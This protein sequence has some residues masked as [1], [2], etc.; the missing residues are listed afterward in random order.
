VLLTHHRSECCRSVFP[1]QSHG[2]RLPA[3][4]DKEHSRRPADPARRGTKRFPTVDVMQITICTI[5]F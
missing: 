3:S 5:L 4:T 2:P 1:V